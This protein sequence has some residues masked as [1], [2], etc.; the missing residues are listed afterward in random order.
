MCD[1]AYFLSDL[2]EISSLFGQPNTHVISTLVTIFIEDQGPVW[3]ATQNTFWKPNL[4]FRHFLPNTK[5]FQKNY[6]T[7]EKLF[8]APKPHFGKNSPFLLLKLQ[9]WVKYKLTL[10][11][12]LSLTLPFWIKL[13]F[14]VID[15]QKVIP[16]TFYPNTLILSKTILHKSYSAQKLF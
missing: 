2:F 12:L 15:I 7:A 14:L 9:K 8:L 10:F 13:S 11:S 6:F 1:W 4:G 16:L 5:K 3:I